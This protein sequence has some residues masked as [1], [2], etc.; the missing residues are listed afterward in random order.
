MVPMAHGDW[1]GKKNINKYDEKTASHLDYF[2]V[3]FIVHAS[4]VPAVATTAQKSENIS[5]AVVLKHWNMCHQ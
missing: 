4:Y 5:R 3:P 1:E 2:R